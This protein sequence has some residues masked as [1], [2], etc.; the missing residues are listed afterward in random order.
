MIVLKAHDESLPSISDLVDFPTVDLPNLGN[1]CYI[2]S[3]SQCLF[4][5]SHFQKFMFEYTQAIGP[6]NAV[7]SISLVHGLYI[8]M[9]QDASVTE[10]R[11]S[12]TRFTKVFL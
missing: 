9:L 1:T 8:Q 12:F 3:V 6:E 2:A 11:A 10:L 7:T 5:I 4:Q